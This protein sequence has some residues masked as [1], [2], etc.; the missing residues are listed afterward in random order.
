VAT[1]DSSTI[2]FADD[3]TVA[4][5]ITSDDETAYREVSKTK[6]MIMDYRKRGEGASMPPFI[7]TGRQWSR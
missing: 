6:D 1:L 3:T 5:L 7:S 2:K 4:G